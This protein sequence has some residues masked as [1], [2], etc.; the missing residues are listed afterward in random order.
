MLEISVS[1]HWKLSEQMIERSYFPFKWQIS[2][3]KTWY[4]IFPNLSCHKTWSICY[5]CN[6]LGNWNCRRCYYLPTIPLPTLYPSYLPTPPLPTSYRPISTPPL[7]IDI[8]ISF[9]FNEDIFPDTIGTCLRWIITLLCN[10]KQSPLKITI[11]IMEPIIELL[12]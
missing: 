6:L 2:C 3:L 9:A 5:T 1:C 11:E 8:V 10:R 7:Q 4:V 12:L